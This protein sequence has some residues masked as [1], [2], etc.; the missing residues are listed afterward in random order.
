MS[1]AYRVVVTGV[2]ESIER[3][4]HLEDGVCGSLDLLP[5]LPRERMQKL[6]SDELSKRGFKVEGQIAKKE[7]KPGITV[8]VD[9]DHSSVTVR[10]EGE[11]ALNLRKEVQVDERIAA[12]AQAQI[13]S[14]L[15]EEASARV[16]RGRQSLSKQLEGELQDLKGEI[17]KAVGGATAEALKEKARAMGEIEEMSEDKETGALTIKVKL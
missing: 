17:D 16:E 1:R 9:L 5:I 12:S 15:E 2:S 14:Q 8:E 13:R 3:V 6:L 4:E 7:H 10:A 11:L